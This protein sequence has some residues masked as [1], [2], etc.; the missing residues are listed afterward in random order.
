MY[1]DSLQRSAFMKRTITVY[2]SFAEADE[3]DKRYYHQ[4]TP[5]E[6]IKIL[7]T[8]IAERHESDEA[9]TGFKRVYRIIKRL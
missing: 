4:L 8:L 1:R 5:A 6:R 7:L 2:N 3:A 9:A